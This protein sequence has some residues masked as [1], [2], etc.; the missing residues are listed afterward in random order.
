MAMNKDR[1]ALFVDN[2]DVMK[3]SFKWHHAMVNRLAALLYAVEDKNVDVPA[4]KENVDR[5]KRN[6][7]IFSTFRGSGTISFAAQLSLSSEPEAQL[8]NALDVLERLRQSKFR[9]SPYLSVAAYQ[10][11]AHS[12]SERYADVVDRAKSFYTE[13]KGNHPYLTGQDDYIFAAMLALSDIDVKAGTERM[14][15]F[16]TALKPELR[17]GNGLQALTQVLV[18]G[19]HHADPVARV[20]R[21]KNA[22][23]DKGIKL[24]KSDTLS[25]LGVLTLLPCED[26]DIVED[27]VRTSEWL[28][29][30]NGFSR[31]SVTTQELLLYASALVAYQ[32]LKESSGVVPITALSTSLT[33]ILIAQ[34][35]AITA[36]ATA[37]AITASSSSD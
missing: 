29:M 10:I 36:A 6:T 35:A 20:R 2:V 37:S 13:M 5:I 8:T 34:Q 27:L 19:Q 23:R 11:A 30:Q 21:L 31:W 1:L 14:E 18:L 26:V 22:F 32:H 4:I 12:R 3:R 7:G 17:I 25:S 9:S 33:N 15:Q 24:D 16:Y 28:R